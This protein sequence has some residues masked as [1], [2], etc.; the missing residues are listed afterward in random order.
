MQNRTR[1]AAR[2]ANTLSGYQVMFAAILSIG[3]ILAINFSSRIT[4][5]Q[6]VQEAYLRVQDE[7][8]ALRAE[9]ELLIRERDY[10]RSDA[11]VEHWARSDG[12]LTRPGDVLIVPVPAAL[13]AEPAAPQ[14][15]A[16]FVPEEAPA[17]DTWRLWWAL[18][19]DGAAPRF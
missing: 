16:V 5:G 6:P 18:F 4:A 11:Y 10:V 15:A 3:L 7:I 17:P 13:A 14:A 9:R 8:A 12:K 19:F 2:S 1:A